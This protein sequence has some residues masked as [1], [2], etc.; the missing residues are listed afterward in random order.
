MFFSEPDDNLVQ[1]QDLVAF[2]FETATYKMDSACAL[3]VAVISPTGEI[4]DQKYWLIKPPK[5]KYYSKNIQIH[6]ITPEQ[7]QD[8]KTFAELWEQIRPYFEKQNIIAH[9]ALFDVNVLYAC[10][11]AAGQQ[12]PELGDIYCSCI[13]ARR[14]LPHLTNHKLPTVCADLQI[15]LL[16]HHNALDDVI[17]CAMI[18]HKLKNHSLAKL[19]FQQAKSQ[20]LYQKEFFKKL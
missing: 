3:G 20:S 11:K 7:T 17:A 8:A 2:D 14:S 15:P 6:G 9:Y 5:N 18:A 16:H 4:K 10:I 19:T 12:L 13:S 1:K